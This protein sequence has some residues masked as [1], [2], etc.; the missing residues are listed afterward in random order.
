[1]SVNAEGLLGDNAE[2]ALTGAEVAARIAPHLS[3]L[4]R[5]A[6]AL[7]GDRAQG[8][9][10]VAKTLKAL[11]GDPASFDARLP[12]D[13]ALFRRF[14]MLALSAAPVGEA[15]APLVRRLGGLSERQ[16][17][18]LLLSSLEGFG[19]A[20]I[21]NILGLPLEEAVDLM[22]IARARLNAE[23]A[24]RILIIEDEDFV[25]D[26]LREIAEEI[27]HEIV[28]VSTT[29]TE[30]VEDARR[31]APD[32]I[33][34]DV[35]LADG[36]TGIEALERISRVHDA[37]VIFVT[38]N[39]EML[40]TGAGVEP[41]YLISKPYTVDEVAAAIAQALFNVTSAKAA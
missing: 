32:L 38:G 1:M 24:I 40:L 22:T 19:A 39:P 26:S 5:F 4:R 41:T 7:L 23:R 3:G 34:S 21:A 27:G 33:L 12:P 37:P 8:D 28:G 16:R 35:M 9:A 10:S 15:D 13:V 36:S 2:R 14:A 18:A 30:A 6:R 31:L 25:A 11:V 17:W 20:P 29:A